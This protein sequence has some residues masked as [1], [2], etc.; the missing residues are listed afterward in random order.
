MHACR[1]PWSQPGAWALLTLP[2]GSRPDLGVPA[3]GLSKKPKVIPL[4]TPTTEIVDVRRRRITLG[5]NLFEQFCLPNHDAPPGFR[6]SKNLRAAAFGRGRR[7][8]AVSLPAFVADLLVRGGPDAL[9]FPT[10][11]VGKC[12]VRTSGGVVVTGGRR[13]EIVPPK[14]RGRGDACL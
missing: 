7:A 3:N 13:S 10:P 4:S 9:V 8:A 2:C 5:R 11:A 6:V 1:N 12:G 14:G